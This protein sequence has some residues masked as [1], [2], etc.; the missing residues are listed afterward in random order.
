MATLNHHAASFLSCST[1]GVVLSLHA[2]LATTAIFA[3]AGEPYR[4]LLEPLPDALLMTLIGTAAYSAPAL[5]AA[6]LITNRDHPNSVERR[7]PKENPPGWSA[8]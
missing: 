3:T 6:P 7:S 5:L 1:L 4:N 8:Q 2:A